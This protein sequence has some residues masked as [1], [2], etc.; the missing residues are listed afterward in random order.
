[1]DT[2]GYDALDVG[3]LADSWRHEAGTPVN[4]LPYVGEPPKS[5]TQEQAHEWM[6]NGPSALV[7]ADRVKELTG[8]A[9]Q[10]GR[11]GLYREDLF[12]VGR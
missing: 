1:M 6:F 2:L 3:S 12:P 9:T 5:M 4:V 7:S 8:R 10:T 11:V